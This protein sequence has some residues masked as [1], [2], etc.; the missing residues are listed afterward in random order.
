MSGGTH[1]ITWDGQV[2][3]TQPTSGNHF[4]HVVLPE[5]VLAKGKL[6]GV[7]GTNGMLPHEPT[8]PAMHWE[9]QAYVQ[10]DQVGSYTAAAGCAIYEGGAWPAK[11]NYSYF[12]GEPTLNIVA[13]SGR[14]GWRHV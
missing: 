10:I 3:Y 14:A 13:T 12:T 4:I 1:A 5:Y 6:P 9:Q 7:M 2:F 11:W 8:Y